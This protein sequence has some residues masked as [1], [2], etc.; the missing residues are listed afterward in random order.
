MICQTSKEK[1]R[2]HYETWNGISS[3]WN[4][5]CC[6]LD[7]ADREREPQGAWSQRWLFSLYNLH[8]MPPRMSFSWAL[9]GD[10][11]VKEKPQ[12]YS[13]Y[14]ENISIKYPGNTGNTVF[15][16]EGSLQEVRS[17]K[18][19]LS[20]SGIQSWDRNA[21][22]FPPK[23]FARFCRQVPMSMMGNL[24]RSLWRSTWILLEVRELSRFCP[25][26]VWQKKGEGDTQVDTHKVLTAQFWDSPTSFRLYFQSEQ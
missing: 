15:P 1:S 16:S 2:E 5:K 6:S 20:L 22:S 8:H 12:S 17:R 4:K 18:R 25:S 9:T 21:L 19:W 14:K 13:N 11:F 24:W 3:K 26:S 7:T 10:N 23:I